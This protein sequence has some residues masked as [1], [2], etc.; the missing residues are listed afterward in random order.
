MAN[1]YKDAAQDDFKRVKTC[2]EKRKADLPE[3]GHTHTYYSPHEARLSQTAD[4]T[5][6]HRNEAKILTSPRDNPEQEEQ[7]N[8]ARTHYHS[9]SIYVGTKSHF[10]YQSA[11]PTQQPSCP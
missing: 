5:P 3:P 11:P 9:C 4:C 10:A 6:C 7:P 8:I 1:N 2:F